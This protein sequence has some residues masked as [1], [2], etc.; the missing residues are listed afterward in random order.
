MNNVVISGRCTK[1]P[2]TRYG[3]E[4]NSVAISR[5]TLAVDDYNSTDFINI[6]CLG[7]QA[8]WVEKWAS[9]GSKLEIVGKIKTG[10]YTNREGKE[11]YYTEV[12]ANSVGFGESKAEA[13][14]RQRNGS[15]RPEPAQ[16]GNDFMQIPEG[17]DEELPFH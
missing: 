10:H 13:E 15:G 3:G 7:R 16:S 1:N 9:K 5:F 4:D 8:E 17:I 6:R 12:L 11:V 14:A 2:E